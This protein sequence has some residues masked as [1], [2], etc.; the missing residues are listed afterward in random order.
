MFA[1]RIFCERTYPVGERDLY[2][3]T[4]AFSVCAGIVFCTFRENKVLCKGDGRVSKVPRICTFPT[5]P[6]PLEETIFIHIFH[7]IRRRMFAHK[8]FCERTYPV[9]ERDLHHSTVAFSVCAGI[10]FDTFRENKV[11]CKGDG[12]V[13]KVPHIRTFPTLPSPLDETT[14]VH[15][16]HVIRRRMF[17]PRIFEERTYPVGER[18]LCHSTVA[19]SVSQCLRYHLRTFRDNCIELPASSTTSISKGGKHLFDSS[20]VGKQSGSPQCLIML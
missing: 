9:G 5:L 16:F 4:V 13:S 6:S 14:L 18:D 11:L 17:A 19:S 7:V 15:I 8:I 2:H 1:H 3:S 10:V 12:R 20:D